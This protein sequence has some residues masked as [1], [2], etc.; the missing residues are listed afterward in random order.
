MQQHFRYGQGAVP[1]RDVPSNVLFMNSINPFCHSSVA[2][3]NNIQLLSRDMLCI[4]IYHDAELITSQML[5][6]KNKQ[7]NISPQKYII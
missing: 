3:F 7:A 6:A 5:P 2:L 1:P 4:K